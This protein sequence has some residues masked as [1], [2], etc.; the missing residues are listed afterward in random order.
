[1][2]IKLKDFWD[3]KPCTLIIVNNLFGSLC[4]GHSG[5]RN[6]YRVLVGKV[7]ARNHMEDLRTGGRIILQWILKEIR[8]STGFKGIQPGTGLGCSSRL[9]LQ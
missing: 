9:P 6:A 4:A 2:K 8:M 3:V 7:E 5:D 1:M